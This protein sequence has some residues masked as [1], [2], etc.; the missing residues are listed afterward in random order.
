[1]QREVDAL[2]ADY[3][4][5]K[6]MN[7]GSFPNAAFSRSSST[8]SFATDEGF[9]EQQ[10]NQTS[11]SAVMERIQ[12]RKSLQLRNQQA[13]WQ[14]LIY[15]LGLWWLMDEMQLWP[16]FLKSSKRQQQ[17]SNL[18]SQAS[19]GRLEMKPYRI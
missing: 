10:D 2:L 3:L 17:Q 7:S 4:A 5:R 9:F 8:D 16:F 11:T 6:R 15:A 12:K 14:V 1:L 19:W 18:L 13:A